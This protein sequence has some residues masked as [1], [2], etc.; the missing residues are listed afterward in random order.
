MAESTLSIES[1]PIISQA[2]I[3]KMNRFRKENIGISLHLKG[4]DQNFS[5]A[6]MADTKDAEGE[7]IVNLPDSRPDKNNLNNEQWQRVGVLQQEN[8]GK[9]DFLI[10]TIGE[11]RR[12]VSKADLAGKPSRVWLS[13]TVGFEVLDFN[14]KTHEVIIRKI[15]VPVKKPGW[16]NKLIDIIPPLII[17]MGPAIL[18]EDPIPPSPQPIIQE[19]PEGMPFGQVL[20]EE[21]PQV[22]APE[23][24]E[25]LLCPA[26]QEITIKAGGSLTKALEEVNGKERYLTEDLKS[27]KEQYFKDLLCLIAQPENIQLL[28]KR[29]PDVA[30]KIKELT[31]E[32]SLNLNGP[33][34]AERLME[35]LEELNKIDPNRREFNEDF[36]LVHPL[37]KVFTPQFS[38]PG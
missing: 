10:V 20:T 9:G 11:I 32:E 36:V 19:A 24:D 33:L 21:I 13:S 18:P 29:D 23:L 15:K 5:L 38:H 22:T 3:E 26:V 1:S 34:I 12:R 37:D 8:N 31:S 35:V 2:K 30:Q 28:E 4:G 25:S 27:N 17:G 14:P 16:R 7:R 6:L